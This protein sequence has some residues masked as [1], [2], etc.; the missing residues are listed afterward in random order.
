M[1]FI[2]S[3]IFLSLSIFAISAKR[4]TDS[5]SNESRVDSVYYFLDKSPTKSLFLINQILNETNRSFEQN[6]NLFL[7]KGNILC[8]LGAYNLA[9]EGFNSLYRNAIKENRKQVKITAL[10]NLGIVYRK[11]GDYDKAFEY[12]EMSSI[13]CKKNKQRQLWLANR[14]KLELLW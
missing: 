13:R 14:S 11:T 6:K 7:L 5:Q 1:R 3:T 9:I 10:R 12:F 4:T 2:F 8:D